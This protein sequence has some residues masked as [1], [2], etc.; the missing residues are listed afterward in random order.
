MLT[1]FQTAE[2]LGW[3]RGFQPQ[4]HIADFPP[5][6]VS[7]AVLDIPERER[8][9]WVMCLQGETPSSSIAI[10]YKYETPQMTR[11]ENSFL[12]HE[13]WVGETVCPFGLKAMETQ[14]QICWANI[15]SEVSEDMDDKWNLNK[16]VPFA[17]A[18]VGENV[19]VDCACTLF[20]FKVYRRY[21]EKMDKFV[22][23]VMEAEVE[24]AE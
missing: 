16:F 1:L 11:V 18:R 22:K 7:E 19:T 10:G 6:Y 13:G 20:M 9:Y 8:W 5:G 3:G 24:V 21:F 17:Q 14:F 2:Y 4:W 23:S 15:T 12:T